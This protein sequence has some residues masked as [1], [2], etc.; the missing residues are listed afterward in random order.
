MAGLNPSVKM[1]LDCF[2]G[3]ALGAGGVATQTAE[4]ATLA[5]MGVATGGGAYSQAR[6]QN[7]GTEQ[8]PGR[9]GGRAPRSPRRRAR[10]KCATEMIP[11]E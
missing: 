6:D 7:V 8:A 9:R 4:R 2:W 1:R 11:A 5:L 3:F 10:S